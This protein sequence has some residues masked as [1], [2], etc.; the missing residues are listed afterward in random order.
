MAPETVFLAVRV[1]AA[2]VLYFFFGLLLYWLWREVKLGANGQMVVPQAYLLIPEA[3]SKIPLRH[4]SEIGRAA[5]NAVQI[6]DETVSARH[7]RMMFQ[8]GQWW[9]EDLASRNG[10]QVNGIP[11][12]EPLVVSYGDE[13]QLGRVVTRLE[14]GAIGEPDS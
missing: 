5:G 2:L 6:E 8:G 7:A 4:T 11:V 1:L 13:I 9:L 3:G 12:E 10:T 14:S